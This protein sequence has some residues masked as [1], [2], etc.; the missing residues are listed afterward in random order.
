MHHHHHHSSGRENLY[1]QGS[2]KKRKRCGVCVPCLRK[3]PCGACY[4]C[5]NRSTSHQICKM[6]KCEQLKKKRVVPMKG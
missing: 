2:N 1:F 6:R 5:V 3:E 4:N